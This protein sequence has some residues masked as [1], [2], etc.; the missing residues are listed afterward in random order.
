MV[1]GSVDP[2]ASEV[3][4]ISPKYLLI[5]RCNSSLKNKSG[6]KEL[7]PSGSIPLFICPTNYVME[8]MW[9]VGTSIVVSSLTQSR[10]RRQNTRYF[11][12]RIF[13]YSTLFLDAVIES[14]DPAKPWPFTGFYGHPKASRRKHSWQLFR[15]LSNPP[16]LFIGDY[17]EILRIS[18]TTG[19][20]DRAP[21][22]MRAFREALAELL[23]HGLGGFYLI[24]GSVAVQ[25]VDL[26][27]DLC[28][29]GSIVRVP[30][31]SGRQPFFIVNRPQTKDGQAPVPGVRVFP[32]MSLLRSERN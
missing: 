19:S 20:E 27:R 2:L 7:V 28:V 30:F 26:G 23:F 14:H 5:G 24:K 13:E 10:S 1:W 16:W 4:P 31:I 15:R 32:I 12:I 21:S 3:H 22:F 11:K 8:L 18:E 25:N 17:N 9:Y 29:I 6:K